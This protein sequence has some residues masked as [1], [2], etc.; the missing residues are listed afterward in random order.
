MK[1]WAKATSLPAVMVRFSRLNTASPSASGC[2]S[3]QLRLFDSALSYF[4]GGKTSKITKFAEFCFRISS[5]R[6]S[7]VAA[8]H[9]SSTVRTSAS[10]VVIVG[11][12]DGYAFQAHNV[13][14]CCG[15]SNRMLRL[16]LRHRIRSRQQQ[17]LI[18]VGRPVQDGR[19]ATSRS[20]RTDW[21]YEPNDGP[22]GRLHV[23]DRL[24]PRHC[25]WWSK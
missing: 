1:L 23:R 19:V 10:A 17:A 6:L 2:H 12:S 9:S 5:L 4:I 7:L 11:S 24:A 8:A 13:S 25:S 22:L 15:H 16:Y 21:S 20:L 14:F 18:C 3:S